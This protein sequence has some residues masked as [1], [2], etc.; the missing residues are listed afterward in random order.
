MDLNE[1]LTKE[2]KDRFQL[3]KGLRSEDEDK[4]IL[5]K[6]YKICIEEIISFIQENLTDE[7]IK[8]FYEAA[9]ENNLSK[10]LKLLET[11]FLDS[12]NSWRLKIRISKFLDNLLLK[13][14]DN[15]K[16]NE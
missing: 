12:Y 10:L 7:E 16:N 15:I 11:F 3:F 2:I 1:F 8:K 9:K 5:E 6:V 4:K 13:S 14:L